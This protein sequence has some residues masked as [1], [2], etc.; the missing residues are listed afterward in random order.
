MCVTDLDLE[1]AEDGQARR[2]GRLGIGS[3]YAGVAWGLVERHDDE[4]ADDPAEADHADHAAA[5]AGA[6]RSR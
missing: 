2:P 1:I 4:A 5:G 3:R 6:A